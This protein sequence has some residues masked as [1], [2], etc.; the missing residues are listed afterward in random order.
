M[1]SNDYK[2]VYRPTPVRDVGLALGRTLADYAQLMRLHRPIGI[3][4]LLWPALWGLW[5]AGDGQ[6][7]ERTFVVFMLGVLLTR[8]AGCVINDYADRDFDPHVQRTRERPLAMGRV[9]PAEALIL[10]FAL[11]LA[12]FALA[13]T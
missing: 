13:M 2:P 6:P 1:S 5:F 8:S 7:A 9:A 4:L 11:G 3:L 10:F 12:C